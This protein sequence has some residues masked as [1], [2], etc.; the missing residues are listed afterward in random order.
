MRQ[1]RYEEAYLVLE[2]V[3]QGKLQGFDEIKSQNR[4]EELLIELKANLSQPKFMDDLDLDDDLVK[5]VDGLLKVWS[6]LD[7]ENF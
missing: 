6:L 4:A 5:G 7:Q 1:S 3:L 2:Q